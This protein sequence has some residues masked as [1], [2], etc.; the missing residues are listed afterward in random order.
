MTFNPTER[1]RRRA[2]RDVSEALEKLAKEQHP[3]LTVQDEALYIGH[4]LHWSAFFKHEANAPGE[5]T[6]TG[7]TIDRHKYVMEKVWELGKDY[8]VF[9]ARRVAIF[10]DQ[11]EREG[12]T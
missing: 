11:E 9:R 6:P 2:C 12:D 7:R 4:L 8:P 10:T 3:D 5:T 1:V